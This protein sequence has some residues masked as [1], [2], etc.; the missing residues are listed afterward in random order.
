MV[1]FDV[2]RGMILKGDEPLVV[3][4]HTENKIK[5]KRK[6]AEQWLESPSLK[7]RSTEFRFSRGGG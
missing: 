6:G 3:K 2:I 4:M 7:I 1:N 5:R